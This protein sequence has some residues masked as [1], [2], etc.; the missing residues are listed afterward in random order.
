MYYRINEIK[1]SILIFDKIVCRV[2]AKSTIFG[3]MVEDLVPGFCPPDALLIATKSINPYSKET[4]RHTKITSL[5]ARLLIVDKCFAKFPL[6]KCIRGGEKG[7]ACRWTREGL[8]NIWV[9]DF[10]RLLLKVSQAYLITL[11]WVAV[12]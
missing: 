9:C 4:L 6:G 2:K 8:E 10:G 3:Q 1:E 12:S 7:L 5:G 11:S